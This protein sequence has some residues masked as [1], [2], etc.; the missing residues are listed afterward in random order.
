MF[1]D[2]SKGK[3]TILKYAQSLLFFLTNPALKDTLYQTRGETPWVLLELDQP[4]G[5]E[6]PNSTPPSLPVLP[7]D[8]S[9]GGVTKLR[10]WESPTQGA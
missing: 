3:V 7:K 1:P 10:T 9:G 5:R 8:D 2:R 4:G 6:I